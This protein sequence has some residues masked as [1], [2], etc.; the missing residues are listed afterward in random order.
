M[1][2]TIVFVAVAAAAALL[3][4]CGGDEG[5]PTGAYV[6]TANVNGLGPVTTTTAR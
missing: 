4:A 2:W 5:F 3:V 6:S 1:R